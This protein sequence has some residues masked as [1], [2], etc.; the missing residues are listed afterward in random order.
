MYLCPPRSPP[1]DRRESVQFLEAGRMKSLAL[2]LASALDLLGC[3]RCSYRPVTRYHLRTGQL[4]RET[5]IETSARPVVDEEPPSRRSRHRTS[6]ARRP[7]PRPVIATR[8]VMGWL[9]NQTERQDC[10]CWE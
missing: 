10:L 5:P 6:A 4:Q 9:P 8:R 2:E 3:A 1:V 7:E